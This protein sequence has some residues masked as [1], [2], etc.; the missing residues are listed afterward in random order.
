MEDFDKSLS[1]ILKVQGARQL[2]NYRNSVLTRYETLKAK[3]NKLGESIKIFQLQLIAVSGGTITLFVALGTSHDVS[4]WIKLGFA[5]FAISMICGVVS[6]FLNQES[7]DWEVMLDEEAGL[8]SEK[9]QLDF[10]DKFGHQNIELDKR[11]TAEKEHL[12]EEYKKN[13]D[14]RQKKVN[15][16]LSVLHLN[17]Q[18]I[19]D[20]QVVLFIGGVILLVV[21]LFF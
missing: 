21:G 14:N 6:L 20:G 5:L 1:E 18:V 12:I 15:V 11:I 2:E 13:I 3:R 17:G 8:Q 16:I 19:A 4:L 7:K 9:M 10:I